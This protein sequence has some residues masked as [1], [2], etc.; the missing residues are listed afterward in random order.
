M[1]ATTIDS[2]VSRMAVGRAVSGV[3]AV[4][5]ALALLLGSKGLAGSG[6]GPLGFVV[7]AMKDLAAPY[8][9]ESGGVGFGLTLGVRPRDRKLNFDAWFW[10]RLV[11]A[12]RDADVT[13]EYI[14]SD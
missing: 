9:V 10:P 6:D 12:T 14:E 2:I 8:V 13:T 11:V 5:E 7:E 4:F 1:K 3:A